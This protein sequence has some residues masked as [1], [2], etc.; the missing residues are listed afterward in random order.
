MIDWGLW[1]CGSAVDDLSTM[2]LHYPGDI[3]QTIL[4]GHGHADGPDFRRRLA[5]A[6]INQ[7]VGHIGWSVSIGNTEGS[8]RGVAML[9][10]VL[11]VSSTRTIDP[12][13]NRLAREHG[14]PVRGPRVLAVIATPPA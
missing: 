14:C 1:H 5:L 13:T 6:V 12:I 11:P 3:F 4:A 8:A 10:A 7:T 2:F 9:R